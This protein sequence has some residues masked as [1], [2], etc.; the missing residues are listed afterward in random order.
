VVAQTT[1]WRLT[2]MID[3]GFW[4]NTQKLQSV[5]S[6]PARSLAEGLAEMVKFL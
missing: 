3:D 5:W 1:F 4:F 2:L 6:E